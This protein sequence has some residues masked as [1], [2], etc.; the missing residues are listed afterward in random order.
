V[1]LLLGGDIEGARNSFRQAIG[2]L[3]A[4][5]RDSEASHLRQQAGALVKLEA[6]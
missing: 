6:A 2:L 5:G 4:Q 3:Q 1:A